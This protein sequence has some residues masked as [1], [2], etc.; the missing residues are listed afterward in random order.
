MFTL[1]TRSRIDG[2]GFRVSVGSRCTLYWTDVHIEY[3]RIHGF[4]PRNPT[5]NLNI[6][7]DYQCRHSMWKSHL[8]M[9]IQLFYVYWIFD[10]LFDSKYSTWT[11]NI[12][13]KC[14]EGYS[15]FRRF[16]VSTGDICLMRCRGISIRR[17]FSVRVPLHVNGQVR[18]SDLSD[19]KHNNTIKVHRKFTIM[20]VTYPCVQRK[21]NHII[22][23][24]TFRSVSP[25][26]EDKIQKA[27]ANWG[28]PW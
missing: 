13:S 10:V 26:E 22:S 7:C 6:R 9:S 24:T 11:W 17:F 14:S 16:D 4:R 1:L 19:G 18:V 8:R 23:S 3:L 2:F 27:A 20:A 12:Q 21:H 5:F 25:R 15:S 28:V